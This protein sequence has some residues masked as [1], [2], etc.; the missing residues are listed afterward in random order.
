[1]ID[2]LLVFWTFVVRV[3]FGVSS[4]R[5]KK[6]L[7]RQKNFIPAKSHA[8]PF[9]STDRMTTSCPHPKAIIN[10]RKARKDATDEYLV[11]VGVEYLLDQASRHEQCLDLS[12]RTPKG[13]NCLQRFSHTD[14]DYCSAVSKYM[15][16][17]AKK[18]KFEQ[19]L[20]VIEWLRY[21]NL[22]GS[23]QRRYIVPDLR[24][25]SE[26]CELINH[27]RRVEMARIQLEKVCDY[28]L[29]TILGYGLRFWRTVQKHA[30]D[31]TTPK[32]GLTDQPS[33][34][35]MGDE[36]QMNLHLFFADIW[37]HAEPTAMQFVREKTGLMTERDREE[38]ESLPTYFTKRSLYRR[39]CFEQG[40]NTTTT[41][42]GT[43]NKKTRRVDDEWKDREQQEIVSWRSFL[44]FWA[45]HYPLLRVGSPSE[46]I[47]N[48]CHKYC[49][50]LKFK[51]EERNVDQDS[52]GSD[53][54][55]DFCIQVATAPEDGSGSTPIK[56]TDLLS[57]PLDVQQN[58]TIILEAT[59][60]VEAARVMREYANTKMSEAKVSNQT[61]A[62]WADAKD[63]IVADYCQNMDLPHQGLT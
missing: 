33:N 43:P 63:C 4:C 42:T 6:N 59:V 17:F 31:G 44:R 53:S 12:K 18:E 61:G 51:R 30:A 19:Q 46:D 48:A 14:Y 3:F 27:P 45:C 29:C 2:S 37:M 24:S 47:C 21:C 54:D 10:N 11:A 16:L 22:R 28:A 7:S 36:T 32:H 50:Q 5:P 58:E 49:N 23:A 40:W 20:T 52:E 60:H 1:M 13:C 35:S 34:N 25:A 38:V 56:N 41:S 55:N 62:S 26:V 15:V 39:Y 57:V 8:L 9:H